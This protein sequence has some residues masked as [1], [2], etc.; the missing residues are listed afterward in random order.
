MAGNGWS[1]QVTSL[2]I[3][4]EGTGFSGLFFYSP[5]VGPGNLVTSI[6]ANSGTDPYGN[7]YLA[8]V[9]SYNSADDT[10]ADLDNAT[11]SFTSEFSDVGP[12]YSGGTLASYPLGATIDSGTTAANKTD[13]QIQLVAQGTVNEAFITA[14]QQYGT[15]PG[16]APIVGSILQNDDSGDNSAPKFVHTGLYTA[17][18]SGAAG[19]ALF[20]HGASFTP[21][22]GLFTPLAHFSQGNWD[23]TFGTDGFTATQAQIVGYLPGGGFVGNGNPVTFYA[24]LMA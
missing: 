9:A 11:L 15:Y 8:G 23:S 18:V 21:T 13:S 22:F 24:M 3:I 5:T 20:T 16:N 2:I 10:T 1:N 4:E 19:Q 14:K 12:S 7:E 6:A 17:T